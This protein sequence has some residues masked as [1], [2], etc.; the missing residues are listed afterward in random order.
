M[1]SRVN[2]VPQR[3]TDSPPV[4][5]P[6]LGSRSFGSHVQVKKLPFFLLCFVFNFVLQ[7]GTVTVPPLQIVDTS[8]L[9][10]RSSGSRVQVTFIYLYVQ[11]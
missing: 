8:S 5:T 6:S 10:N 1:F 3:G 4:T 9:G 11:V 7:R 2:L